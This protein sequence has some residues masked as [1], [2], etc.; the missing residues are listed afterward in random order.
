MRPFRD[1]TFAGSAPRVD[2]L[3]APGEAAALPEVRDT[4]IT[5]G[6]RRLGAELVELWDHREL[7]YFLTWRDV[8]VRYKQAAL[9]VAWAIIQPV[10]TM[11][12]FSVIFGALAKLPTGG[13]PYPLFSYAGLLPWQ[14][15]SGAVQRASDSIVANQQLVT[16][17]YFPRLVIPFSAVAAT[18]VD[19]AL[20]LIVFLGMMVWYRV[21]V[22]PKLLLVPVIFFGV[23]LASLGVGMWLAAL[24]VKYRDVR[25]AVPFM[26]QFWM[27]ASPV[28][29]AALLLPKGLWSFL[30]YLNPMAGLIEAMRWATVGSASPGPVALVS[31]FTT[32]AF[33]LLGGA[34]FRRTEQTFA[35]VI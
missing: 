18:L 17:V 13:I 14:L 20:A 5:G 9:G 24:N 4:I 30:Y 16:K 8:A 35:D 15:F 2:P 32:V 31:I 3:S 12:I 34:Y 10:M 29:Y 23:V 33:L 22:T 11:I 1:R 28:A 26:L 19:T 7:L 6:H 25:H 27:Y 21:P